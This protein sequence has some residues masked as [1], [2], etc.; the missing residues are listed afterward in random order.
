[1]QGVLKFGWEQKHRITSAAMLVVMYVTVIMAGWFLSASYANAG[2]LTSVKDTLGNS[3]PASVSNHTIQFTVATTIPAAGSISVDFDTGFTFGSVD[4]T[5]VDIASASDYTLAAAAT[6]GTLG[7]TFT[8]STQRMHIAL[9]NTAITA[10]TVL[11]IEIGFN[12]TFTTTGDQKITNPSTTGSKAVDISTK[13][14]SNVE[15][16]SARTFVAIVN[17][18]TLNAVVAAAF[19]FTIDGMTTSESIDSQV[20]A[21]ASSANYVGFGTLTAGTPILMG[22]SLSVATNAANGFVVTIQ[23]NHNMLASSGADIDCFVDGTCTGQTSAAWAS[24]VGTLGSENTYGHLGVT[25]EDSAT[26][27]ATASVTGTTDG[28]FIGMTPQTPYTIWSNSTP[29]D[30]IAQDIGHIDV[31]YRVQITALQEAGR[32]QSRV[33]YIATPTF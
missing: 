11:T 23:S 17:P 29:A 3:A 26:I 16:D 9:G 6:G 12:A 32:Y 5:D 28:F 18:I 1:M 21:S 2:T 30:G 27:S 10:G 8:E 24:P 4:F 25:S 31:G 22:S 19:T 14:T 15:L 33:M 13:D 20:V 7:V